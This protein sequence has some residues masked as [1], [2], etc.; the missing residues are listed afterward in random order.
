[1]IFTLLLAWNPL[2]CPASQMHS[3]HQLLLELGH[4][5]EILLDLGAADLPLGGKG[6]G[7][8]GFLHNPVQQPAAPSHGPP[9][10]RILQKTPA[11][12]GFSGVVE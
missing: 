3:H 5:L 1:M 4:L 9:G 8:G 10:P 6:A 11:R 2:W 12:G 7:H